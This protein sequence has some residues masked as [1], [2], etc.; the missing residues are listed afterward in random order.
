MLF[1]TTF[2][3]KS[4]FYTS[5]QPPKQ[6]TR[7]RSTSLWDKRVMTDG[8]IKYTGFFRGFYIDFFI[9]SKSNVTVRSLNPYYE[10][11]FQKLIK[12]MTEHVGVP[13]THIMDSYGI[14]VSDKIY[15]TKNLTHILGLT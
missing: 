6:E 14:N 13:P 8:V 15:I 3:A 12:Y 5:E 10:D 4:V 1:Q 7:S 2:I 11:M 9:D